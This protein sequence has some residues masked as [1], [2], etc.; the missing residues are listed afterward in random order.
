MDSAEVNDDLVGDITEILTL[1]CARLHGR[2]VAAKHP[3][4]AVEAV[5]GADGQV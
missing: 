2:G 5:T 3:R 4:R 1:M